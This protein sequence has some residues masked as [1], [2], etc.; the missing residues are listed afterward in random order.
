MSRIAACFADAKTANRKILIPYVMGGDPSIDDSLKIMHALVVAGAD[1]IELGMPFS[2]PM[3]DGP[4]I[5]AASERVLEAG[6]RLPA[7]FKLVKLFRETND[8]TPIVLMGYAN[9]IEITGYEAFST[10]AAEAGV[11]GVITVDMPPEEAGELT[12]AFAK[13]DL[14][15]IFL[16]SPTTPDNR[17]KVVCDQGGGFIYYVSLKGVTGSAK[18]DTDEVATKVS[19]IK[20][21]SEMPVGVGFGI[22]D[23]SSAAQVAAVADAVVVGSVIVRKIA[24]NA[25]DVNKMLAEV[26][27][28]VG[29]MRSAIDNL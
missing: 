28:L 14:D 22:T 29:G 7:I 27:E 17:V 12:K 21:L 15:P 11:D 16:I 18:L 25:S 23:A 10:Q 13:H 26:T 2:D 19:H 1:I 9:P 6:I 3:A 5:Q 4:V 8:K 20:E 24:E